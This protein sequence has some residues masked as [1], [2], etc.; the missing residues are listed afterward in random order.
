MVPA[1]ATNEAGVTVADIVDYLGYNEWG[2][3][4]DLL[5]DLDGWPADAQWWDLLIEAAE[6]MWL[7]D[8]ATWCRWRRWESIHGII[9]AQLTLVPAAEGGRQTP[10][11]GKGVLRP[12]WHIGQYLPEGQPN[13]RVARIWVEY[14][15]ELA[16]GATGSVRLAPLALDGWRDLRP[17]QTITMHEDRSVQATATIIGVSIPG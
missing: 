10:V 1:N 9:R 13:F 2:V 6:L 4:L 5:A 17:D 8:T 15:P 12:L 7:P 11:P 3:A 16:P 14:A